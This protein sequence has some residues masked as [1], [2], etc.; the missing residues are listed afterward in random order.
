[1]TISLVEQ[2]KGHESYTYVGAQ[3]ECDPRSN[4]FGPTR[5]SDETQFGRA[6]QKPIKFEKPG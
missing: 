1:M 4:L 6:K 2:A 3:R 5:L